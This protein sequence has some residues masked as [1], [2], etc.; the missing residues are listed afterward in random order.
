MRACKAKR[1]RRVARMI[2]QPSTY[3]D[4]GQQLR[5]ADGSTRK[6]YNDLKKAYIK[7]N[8][9]GRALFFLKRAG[10]LQGSKIRVREQLPN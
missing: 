9:Y 8:Q 2:G 1:L 4:N 3:V 10:L 6:I 5:W 7:E